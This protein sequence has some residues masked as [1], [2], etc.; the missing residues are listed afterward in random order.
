[1]STRSWRMKTE[2]VRACKNSLSCK[3][4]IYRVTAIGSRYIRY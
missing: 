4:A 1:M 3:A 2:D